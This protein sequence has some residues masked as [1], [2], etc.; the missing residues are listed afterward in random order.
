MICNQKSRNFCYILVKIWG[1]GLK[2][3]SK[4]EKKIWVLVFENQKSNLQPKNR[5][6]K[7]SLPHTVQ[8]Q[9]QARLSC[10]S[11]YMLRGQHL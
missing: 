1:V 9:K 7:A 8:R 2:N 3:F 4:S 6:K 10:T 5:N 11:G